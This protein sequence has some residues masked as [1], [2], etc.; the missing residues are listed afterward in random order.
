MARGS[1]GRETA[2][3]PAFH[4]GQ[5]IRVRNIHTSGHTRL[6]GYLRGHMGE[7]VRHHGAH[8]FPNANAHGMGEN[9]QHLYCVRFQAADVFAAHSPDTLHA[10]MWEPYLEAV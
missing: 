7:I 5:M 4:M 10:D 1:Y 3:I 8:V 9:P 6:P 2:V